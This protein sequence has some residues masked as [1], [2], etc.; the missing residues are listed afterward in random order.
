MPQ[1]GQ[2]LCLNDAI[3][4][5][6]LM[7]LLRSW[8]PQSKQYLALGSVHAG[9]GF[10]FARKQQGQYRFCCKPS[11]VRP[12]T[13]ASRYS[14]GIFRATAKPF[15]VFSLSRVVLPRSSFPRLWRCMPAAVASCCWLQR[16]MVSQSFDVAVERFLGLGN[17][18][19]VKSIHRKLSIF[20]EVKCVREKGIS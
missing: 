20:P 11:T 14:S 10:A 8:V 18:L 1:W 9:S 12:E 15:L 3:G 16:E 19:L 2:N 7:Q 4:S 17:G 5:K 13:T 6:Q